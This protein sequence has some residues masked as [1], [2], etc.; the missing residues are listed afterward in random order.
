MD[1][2]RATHFDPEPAVLDILSALE[3]G[4][5]KEDSDVVR[6]ILKVHHVRAHK[7]RRRVARAVL[8]G[9]GF[10]PFFLDVLKAVQPVSQ[11]MGEV[12]SFLNSRASTTTR[13]ASKFL[14]RSEAAAAALPFDL[15]NFPRELIRQ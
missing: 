7:D 13:R 5:P 6:P 2:R 1:S 4:T 10:E 9:P 8:D 14:I 11:M 3:Y 15:G 12:Y